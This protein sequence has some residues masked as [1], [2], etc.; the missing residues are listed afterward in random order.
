MATKCARCGSITNTVFLSQKGCRVR[1]APDKEGNAVWIT[2]CLGN[3][4]LE[5]AFSFQR[6]QIGKNVIVNDR[7][8]TWE[9]ISSEENKSHLE[10]KPKWE[11]GYDQQDE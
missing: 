4:G 9:E 8:L 7:K 11:G 5:G 1:V 6:D 2:G 3:K 10:E